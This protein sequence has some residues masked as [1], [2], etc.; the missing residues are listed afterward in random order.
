MW[1][2]FE[3][4]LSHTLVSLFSGVTGTRDY[5]DLTESTESWFA[6]PQTLAT[7]VCS[8]CGQ[9]EGEWKKNINPIKLMCVSSGRMVE[10]N[11]HESGSRCHELST[12]QGHQCHWFISSSAAHSTSFTD[13]K[14]ETQRGR[15]HAQA[16]AGDI[17]RTPTYTLSVMVNVMCQ[18]GWAMQCLDI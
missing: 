4:C 11:Q 12:S 3:P 17:Q 15:L 7:G 6:V 2:C 13:E 14:T 9:E 16:L 10:T 8:N 18:L 1:W 5:N